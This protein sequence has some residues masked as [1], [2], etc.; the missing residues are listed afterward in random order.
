MSELGSLFPSDRKTPSKYLSSEECMLLTACNYMPNLCSFITYFT[1]RY[2]IIK[3]A[4]GNTLGHK[5]I[6]FKIQSCACTRICVKSKNYFIWP[7]L[8][9]HPGQKKEGTRKKIVFIVRIP[10][11]KQHVTWRFI[12]TYKKPCSAPSH[13]L[14]TEQKVGCC[15]ELENTAIIFSTGLS[16]LYNLLSH[17]RFPV[18][19][20]T[21]L[22]YYIKLT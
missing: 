10:E 6:L 22:I 21:Y 8:G 18:L 2:V 1:V 17:V 4:D 16:S 20:I 3:I 14:L 15:R 11:N 7:V 19:M 13:C 5:N 9:S 12:R